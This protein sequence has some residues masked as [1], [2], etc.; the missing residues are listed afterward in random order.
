MR[1][2]CQ[3]VDT[4]SNTT[5]KYLIC[6]N[7]KDVVRFIVRW[8]V[9]LRRS[10]LNN[11]TSDGRTRNR[12]CILVKNIAEAIDSVL[13]ITSIR[14][15]TY[16]SSRSKSKVVILRVCNERSINV[17]FAESTWIYQL[18]CA[19][20]YLIGDASSPGVPVTSGPDGS[21]FAVCVVGLFAPAA[22]NSTLTLSG[23]VESHVHQSYNPESC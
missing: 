15:T 11:E 6:F 13:Q 16:K 5:L 14:Y 2:E 22:I 12:E 10:R 18:D 3:I 17:L 21:I 7:F 20:S 19:V 4:I 23:S 1:S 8:R 9:S